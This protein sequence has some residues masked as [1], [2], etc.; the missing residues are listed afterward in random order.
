MNSFAERSW[1]VGDKLHMNNQYPGIATDGKGTD[2]VIW[3]EATRQGEHIMLKAFRD[4]AAITDDMQVSGEGLA[5]RP[6]IRYVG[7]SAWIAWS[8]FRDGEWGIYLRSYDGASLSDTV[9]IEKGQAMF[10]VSLSEIDGEVAVAYNRQTPGK[11]EVRLAR[12]SGGS[13]SVE[14]VNIAAKC[15]RPTAAQ[16]GNGDILIVYDSFDG[17]TYNVLGR[18]FSNGKWLDE[19]RYDCS[20]NRCA[21]PV[22]V[23]PA[24]D[25]FVICWYENGIFSYYSYNAVDVRVKDGNAELS[26]YQVLVSN[27]NWY[28]NIDACTNKEGYTVFCYTIGKYNILASIR[29]PDG[30]WSVPVLLSY[31]DGKCGIRPKA[32]LSDDG[33]IHYVWQW[34]EKNGHEDRY[35]VVVCNTVSIKEALEH[36][37]SEIVTRI[38]KFVQPI[39]VVKTLD[40]VPEDK[41][42]AWLRKNGIKCSLLFGDIHGQSNMSDGMGELDHYYHYAMVDSDMD[43]C[44]LTD[45]DC[46]PDEATQ[47][48]WEWNRATRNLFNEEKDFS[49]LLAF[50]W[51]SNEYHHDFGHKNVYYPSSEGGLYTS[52]SEEGMNPD[53]LYASIK[54]D[55]GLCIPHHPA[56]DWGS[57]SAATDWDYYDPEVQRTVEIF[58]RHADYERTETRSRYTKNIAKFPRKCAQ[59][60]L[61]RGYRLGFVAG[62]D[63]HQMEHGK[64]GGILGA[65]MAENTSQALWNAIW[66]RKTYGTTGARIL[67]SF[68]MGDAFMGDE[69]K[70]EGKREFTC[71]AYAV[72]DIRKIEIIKNGEPVFTVAS[73]DSLEVDFTFTDE[74]SSSTDYY[75]LRVEQEDDHIAWS[76]PIFV[77]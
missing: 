56:A 30:T 67:L 17:H 72:N 57:V 24:N 5:L 53:R 9:L 69:V 63:S 43:F 22:V 8:E 19:L 23:S 66:N 15:Y 38:D 39:D 25:L 3:E 11:S 51:T 50:E 74:G 49:V 52:L 75:Y 44:A 27:R 18:I 59:D 55:G 77:N 10:Y 12:K 46:Y 65:F 36:D 13:F 32:V 58:S 34:A 42:A 35:A 14:T 2:F 40:S 68:K 26:N 6:A 73:P 48:E 20:D 31:N 1:E 7:S 37:D 61:A 28:N 21:Q 45:H 4:G 16:D 76:S 62:S 29:K 60:A 71:S 33:I 47:A 70:I 64:E 54:K 41:K